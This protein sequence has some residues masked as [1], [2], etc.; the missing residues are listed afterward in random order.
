LPEKPVTA[1]DA[2]ATRQAALAPI[3]P[4]PTP[5]DKAGAIAGYLEAAP[6]AAGLDTLATEWERLDDGARVCRTGKAQ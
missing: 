3:C 6:P 2:K 5:D 1:A 4:T